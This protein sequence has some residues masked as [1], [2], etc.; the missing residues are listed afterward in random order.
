MAL[1]SSGAISL[2]NVQTEFGGS[3]PTS[4]SEYYAAASGV[5]ASG[6]ISLSDFYGASA[7]TAPYLYGTGSVFT[8]VGLSTFGTIKSTAVDISFSTNPTGI[9]YLGASS[10]GSGQHYFVVYGDHADY[11]NNTG[12]FNWFSLD[13]FQSPSLV[14]T[15]PGLGGMP[16]TYDPL[17]NW[18]YT[19]GTSAT[20]AQDAWSSLNFWS[21]PLVF[22][23]T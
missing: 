8:D 14:T 12:S 1:Q 13:Q 7:F 15:T 18:T 4:I 9:Q 22:D 19:E 17:N 21:D 5:P 6:T 3:A 10:T 23:F 11:L 16:W 2:A 20:Q